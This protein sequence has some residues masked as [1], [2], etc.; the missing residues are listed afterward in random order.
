MSKIKERVIVALIFIPL[1]LLLIFVGG[2]GFLGLITLVIGFSLFEFYRCLGTKEGFLPLFWWGLL[3][4]ILLPVLGYFGGEEGLLRTLIGVILFTLFLQFLL[5]RIH[6][7]IPEIPY[8][9]GGIFYVSLLLSFILLLR[10]EG[11]RG[12]TYAL[13]FI[14]WMGDSGAYFLGEVVGFRAQ[15]AWETS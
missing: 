2:V 7:S 8:T 11:G 9:L 5:R 14:T 13:F 12:L 4:G 6:Q 10:K 15:A 3:G 1:F